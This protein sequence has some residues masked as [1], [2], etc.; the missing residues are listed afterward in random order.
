MNETVSRQAASSKW[1]A[2]IAKQ[3]KM[4]PYL[5]TVILPRLTS[6]GLTLSTP[7]LVKGG[8]SAITLFCGRSDIFCCPEAPCSRRHR[9]QL[10]RTL[11]IVALALR[12]Q[13]FR[14]NLDKTWLRSLL[15]KSWWISCRMSSDT[16]RS[17]PRMA[18]CLYSSGMA[19]RLSLSQH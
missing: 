6:K 16:R 13:Y 14:C 5:F 12:I 19:T 3:V 4:T 18:G 7:V 1:R 17:L 9:K 8:S 10:D 11:L 15:P 2:R